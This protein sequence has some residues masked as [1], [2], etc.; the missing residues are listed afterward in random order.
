MV[1]AYVPQR[2]KKSLT[3]NSNY[4]PQGLFTGESIPLFEDNWIDDN[5]DNFVDDLSNEMVFGV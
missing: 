2:V 5:L 3:T 1:L 4:S